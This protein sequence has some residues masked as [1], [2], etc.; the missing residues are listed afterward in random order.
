M[1]SIVLRQGLVVGTTSLE[2]GDVL[3][4]DGEIVGVGDLGDVASGTT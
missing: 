1:S 2:I 3:I 4:V